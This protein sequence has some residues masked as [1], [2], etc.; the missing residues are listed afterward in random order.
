MKQPTPPPPKEPTP[1]PPTPPKEEVKDVPPQK[2]V[3]DEP[4]GSAP[5]SNAP[6]PKADAQNPL[7]DASNRPIVIINA[8][9]GDTEFQK[10]LIAALGGK[11]P[12]SEDN[13]ESEAAQP[14][15]SGQL[16]RNG[17]I[18]GVQ[19]GMMAVNPM[20]MSIHNATATYA[21]TTG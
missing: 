17:G 7:G 13:D 19:P 21:I 5:V 3:S 16:G 8:T 18:G 15:N 12:P 2:A 9:P 11:V 1:P 10:T 20:M 4:T 14:R 6:D